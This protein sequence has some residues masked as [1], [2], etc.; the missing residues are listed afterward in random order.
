MSGEGCLINLFVVFVLVIQHCS[1]GQIRDIE[2]GRA[3]DTYGA[4]GNAE[5]DWWQN[6]KERNHL[7][8]ISVDGEM[9]KCILQKQEGTA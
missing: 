1:G 6:L 3:S 9:L 5:S 4:E 8:D 2:M 7:E